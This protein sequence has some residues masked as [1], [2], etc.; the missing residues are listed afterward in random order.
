MSTK[1]KSNEFR[2]MV[3]LETKIALDQS[4]KPSK[5]GNKSRTTQ[6]C[7]ISQNRHHKSN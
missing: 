2:N 6:N 4:W 1:I 7:K 3:K 5:I